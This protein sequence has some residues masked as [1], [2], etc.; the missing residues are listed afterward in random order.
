MRLSRQFLS[1]EIFN[2]D[3]NFHFLTGTEGSLES[4]ACGKR[5]VGSGR[6]RVEGA[7]DRFGRFK[8]KTEFT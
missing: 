7:E 3:C 5:S 6:P 2:K 4:T 1:H 8:T